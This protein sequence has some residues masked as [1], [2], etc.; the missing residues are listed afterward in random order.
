VEIDKHS[1]ETLRLNRPEWNVVEGDL[2][3]FDGRPYYGIDLLAGGVP[4]PPFSVA[5]KRLGDK[6]ER[7]LFPEVLRLTREIRPGAVMIE[8]VRGIMDSDFDEYRARF[9]RSLGELGYRVVGWKLL[10]ASDFGVPQL[11]PRKHGGPDLGPTRAKR[12]WSAL[13][14]NGHLVAN[15]P[16]DPEFEGPCTKSPF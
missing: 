4:C 2:T 13:G 10:N 3:K 12:A 5:G 9:A 1:C 6:D 15:E 16:P 7:D 8:N 11:R 14:V